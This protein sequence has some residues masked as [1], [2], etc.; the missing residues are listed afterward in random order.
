MLK[1]LLH[2]V[3][4]KGDTKLLVV[5]L[6]ILN[7]FSKFFSLSDFPINLQHVFIK[8]PTEPH[9]RRYTTL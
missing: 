6:L 2:G 4:K 7:Q 3:P 5:T 1:K 8:D 9:M